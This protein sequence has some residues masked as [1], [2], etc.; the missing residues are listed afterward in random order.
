VSFLELMAMEMVRRREAGAG[1][2][3]PP[4]AGSEQPALLSPISLRAADPAPPAP[5]F[6][7]PHATPPPPA[8]QKA[9]G[10]YVARGLSFRDAEFLELEAPLTER[11]AAL[12]DACAALW[13]VAGRRRRA[14]GGARGQT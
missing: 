11:Q 13:Q 10:K 9:A 7:N 8:L 3:S 2:R 12:Y 5:P 14:V 6:L 1:A 4:Q